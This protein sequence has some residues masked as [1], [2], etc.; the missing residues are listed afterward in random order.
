MTK[1]NLII[2]IILLTIIDL[3]AAGWYVSRRIE[4]SG[5]SQDL[6]NQRDST[7][8][9]AMADTIITTSQADL[10]DKMQFNTYYYI[11]NSPS[12]K[13]DPT[14]Y[15]TS[16]KHVK[17]KWPLKVNGESQLTELNKELI[18]KAFDNAQTQM[19]DARYVYLKTPSFN[20]PIGD[21]YRTLVKAPTTYPV[22]GNVSQVL[23]YPYMTS[24][25]LLVMEIDKTEYNG[26]TNIENNSYIHY[27]RM[28]QRVLSRLDILVADVSKE[29]KLLKL[30]NNKIDDLNKGR[31]NETQLQHALNVP[32][33]IRCGKKGVV[34]QYKHGTIASSPVEIL[35]DYDKLEPFFT[36]EFKQLVKENGKYKVFNDDIKPEPIHSAVAK[37]KTISPEISKQDKK[38]YQPK[39]VKPRHKSRKR[40]SGARHKSGYHGYSGKRRWN[41][42]RH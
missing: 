6:F 16:I 42:Y 1:K 38:S 37:P 27:D 19:K 13:G 32:A 25:R 40:Y 5:K 7:Q 4:A 29:N 12:V 41:R 26:S 39:K 2:V 10:F 20:K 24:Q 15:Y 22:Y 33:E 17:V 9:I 31:G 14:S 23:V 11:S 35:I 36:N 21:D 34:F 3:L 30:I 18:K 28:Q 8:V